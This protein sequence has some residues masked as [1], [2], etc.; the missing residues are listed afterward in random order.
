ML[1]AFVLRAGAHP[2][3]FGLNR[4]SRRHHEPFLGQSPAAGQRRVRALA[5]GRVSGGAELPGDTY[6][7]AF[8][9]HNEGWTR[10]LGEM[11]A[12]LDAA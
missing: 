6:R 3:S 1:E 12:Y 7:Q 2:H 11:A 8:D 5:G 10:E 9:G 4:V